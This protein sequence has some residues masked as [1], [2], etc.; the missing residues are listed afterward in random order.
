MSLLFL[1]G[2]LEEKVVDCIFS[3]VDFCVFPHFYL[4]MAVTL[5]KP[6]RLLFLNVKE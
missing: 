4:T 3:G 5:V 6:F 2:L 1:N